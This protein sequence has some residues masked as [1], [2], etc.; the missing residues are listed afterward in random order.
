[1]PRVQKT[2]TMATTP[3]AQARAIPSSMPWIRY[4]IRTGQIVLDGLFAFLAFRIAWQ[5]RYQYEV[6][7]EVQFYDWRPF[8]QFQDRALLFAGLVVVILLI[9]GVYWLPRSSGLLDESVMIIGGLTTAMGGV[10]LTAFL[11]RFVPSRLVFIYAWAIAILLFVIRRM[12]SRTLRAALWQRGIF[13]DRVL[14]VGSGESGRRIM[15]AM[16]NNPAL[17]Y[18]LVGFV[19]DLPDTT[20]L[21]VATEHK[22]YRA[23]RVGS[24][25]DL[26]RLVGLHEV[27]EV[28]VALPA[29]ELHAVPSIIE[30]CQ[31]RA[32]QF[33]VVPDLL[34]LSLDRVD[35]GE[36]G[37][38]PLIGVKPASIQ[39]G[40]LLAKR[41]ID[42]LVATAVLV[43]AAA[44]MAVIALLVRATSPGPVLYRQ[45]RIGKDGKRFTLVKFRCMVDG[46]DEMR[47]ELM[48]QHDTQDPRLFKLRDDPR[49]TRVG[50]VLRRW[51]LDE[52]PQFWHVLMGDMSLVGPRPQMPEEV[53]NYEEW[54][55]Q[56]L[57]VTPGLTGL[58][59]VNGRSKLSFDE[60]V[61]LDLYYAEHWSPW[62]DIKIVLRTV[63]A[64]ILGRGAY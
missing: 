5:L 24:L 22:V 3:R 62:L 8:S 40:Q 64:V 19:N 41:A 21:S 52:L 48:A 27:D 25:K 34:Q 33:K 11:T 15:E 6:G 20:D 26:E 30:R 37:G 13:V 36:V 43:A 7:G 47:A 18:K 49:L 16:L 56:R 14:V 51:S 4:G 29:D 57:A 32:V 1:M 50:R 17:G 38:L 23:P 42:A 44:P 28:I 54:H 55:L 9:R 61:R 10:L 59:Q 31:Q 45:T 39:G 46:A 2:Q 58:W 63:P 12:F 60:M 53:A 35:L